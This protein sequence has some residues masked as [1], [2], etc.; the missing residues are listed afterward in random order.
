MISTTLFVMIVSITV[1]I[2]FQTY[3]SLEV[4]SKEQESVSQLISLQLIKPHIRLGEEI[5]IEENKLLVTKR[6]KNIV[7]FYQS[8]ENLMVELTNEA[9]NQLE[10][11]VLLSKVQSVQFKLNGPC[12]VTIEVT[13]ENKQY[14][15]SEFCR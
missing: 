12:S 5:R 6:D 13:S 1:M 4:V 15:I 11:S 14:H 2:F 9:G 7:S 10:Q 8:S 3:K